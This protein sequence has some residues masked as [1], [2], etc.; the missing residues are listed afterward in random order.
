MLTSLVAAIPAAF[1]SYVLIAAMIFHSE[2]LTTIAYVFL[3]I[4][5]IAA[6]TAA[7][8]PVG[9]IVG[10]KRKPPVEQAAASKKGSVDSESAEEI[11]AIDDDVEAMEDSG[12]E[13]EL[14]ESSEFD[15]GNSSDDELVAGSDDS[16]STDAIDEFDLDD[17]EEAIKPKP[18]KKKSP[19]F[20]QAMN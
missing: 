5:L 17:E 10:G 2:N 6:L 19:L 1:L 12:S 13:M 18:K 14:L 4:T 11:E 9:I 16:L 3:G 7:L 15:I 8:M 20:Y